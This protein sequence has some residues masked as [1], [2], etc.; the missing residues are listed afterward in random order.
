MQFLI[1]FLIDDI[2]GDIVDYEEVTHMQ[3]AKNETIQSEME[4]LEE[5]TSRP[6]PEE[7]WN[8]LCLVASAE[9]SAKADSEA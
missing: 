1:G 7:Y 4:W 9:E 3:E 5:Y 2:T 6:Y 8:Y